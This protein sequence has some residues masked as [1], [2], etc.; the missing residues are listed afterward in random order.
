L[1]F[2]NNFS[3]K[4]LTDEVFISKT[5]KCYFGISCHIHRN[6]DLTPFLQFKH[7]R[8]RDFELLA[9]GCLLVA[10]YS[11]DINF[12]KKTGLKIFSYKNTRDIV[13][14]NKNLVNMHELKINKIIKNNSKILMLKHTW[15]CRV[16]K[17]FQLI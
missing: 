9:L 7:I 10:D 16:N 15:E 11:S 13:L 6:T 8:M 3:S 17:I 12:L 1:L 2:N 14:I 5:Q 4:F